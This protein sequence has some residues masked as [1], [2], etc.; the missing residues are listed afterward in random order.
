MTSPTAAKVLASG[1]IAPDFTAD[2][3]SG[4]PVTL[5]SFQGKKRVLL[6][7]SRSPSPRRAR[8]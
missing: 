5:S 4:Q 8:L 6:A 1:D 3:T 2:S 7:F